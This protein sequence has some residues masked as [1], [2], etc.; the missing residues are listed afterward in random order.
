MEKIGDA[1]VRNRQWFMTG[2]DQI[3][4]GEIFVNGDAIVVAVQ[5]NTLASPDA[6]PL[7]LVPV[8]EFPSKVLS[9]FGPECSYPLTDKIHQDLV[10]FQ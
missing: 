6:R 4:A 5:W 9:H 2:F 1:L 3:E 10:G 8:A 7:R